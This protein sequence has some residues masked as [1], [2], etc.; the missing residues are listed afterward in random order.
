VAIPGAL[1]AVQDVWITTCAATGWDVEALAVRN[2]SPINVVWVRLEITF[3]ADAP[4][5]AGLVLKL[6]ADRVVFASPIPQQVR[7]H[8]VRAQGAADELA[9]ADVD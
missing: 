5:P 6:P 4:L 1:V 7:D 9:L 2:S 3:G 8:R